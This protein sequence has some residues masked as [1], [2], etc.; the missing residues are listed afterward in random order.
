M[1]FCAVLIRISVRFGGD[2]TALRLPKGNEVIRFENFDVTSMVDKSIHYGQLLSICFISSTLD[3]YN[4]GES[5]YQL[6]RYCDYV[7][8]KPCQT[9]F[10]ILI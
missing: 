8:L 1:L 3:D 9:I 6:R 7:F 10:E 5:R 2:R 4:E